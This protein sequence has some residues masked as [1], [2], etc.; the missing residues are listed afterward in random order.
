MT[1]RELNPNMI[2]KSLDVNSNLLRANTRSLNQSIQTKLL[3]MS[4]RQDGGVTYG[5]N[6]IAIPRS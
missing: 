3:M 1:I 5:N 2:I 6:D 4:I